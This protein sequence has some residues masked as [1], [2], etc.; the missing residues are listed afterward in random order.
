M[1]GKVIHALTLH[2][3]EKIGDTKKE[4][5]EVFMKWERDMNDEL[6]NFKPLPIALEER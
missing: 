6:Y 1:R 5:I 3:F 4:Q 2:K